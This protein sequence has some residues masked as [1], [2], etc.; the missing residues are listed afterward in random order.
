MCVPSLA[1]SLGN[2]ADVFVIRQA[3]LVLRIG[4][5]PAVLYN[6]NTDRY[7]AFFYAITNTANVA[8]R[9]HGGA[10]GELNGV[11]QLGARSSP[12]RLTVTAATAAGNIPIT[13][14]PFDVN[15]A[16]P[17]IAGFNKEIMIPDSESAMTRL[18]ITATLADT[19]TPLFHSS[20]C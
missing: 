15:T 1:R 18:V 5:E 12:V 17:G 11:S 10:A 7:N 14:I 3:E 13:G 16:F 8:F 20:C 2:V 6:N 9:L 4:P 19:L